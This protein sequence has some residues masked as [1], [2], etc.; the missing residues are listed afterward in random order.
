MLGGL[1]AGLFLGRLLGLGPEGNGALLIVLEDS[2]ILH[3]RWGRH[4][5]TR[6][7]APLAIL[8]NIVVAW[9]WFGVN[10]LGIGLH[11]YGFMEGAQFWLVFFMVSQLFCISIGSIPI[12]FWAALETPQVPKFGASI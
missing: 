2:L 4:C 3:A 1:W 12:H 9:S 8:G 11:S 5:Q 7:V 10:M 6:G